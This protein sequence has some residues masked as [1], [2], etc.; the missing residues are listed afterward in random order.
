MAISIE[1]DQQCEAALARVDEIFDAELGTPE[2]DELDALVTAI[3]LYEDKAFFS[4]IAESG[5]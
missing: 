3:E 1:T 5:T 4:G 2:G